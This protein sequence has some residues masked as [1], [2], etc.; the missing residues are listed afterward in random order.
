MVHRKYLQIL[1]DGL[2]MEVTEIQ[3]WKIGGGKKI[4]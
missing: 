3:G 1:M 2:K 4:K